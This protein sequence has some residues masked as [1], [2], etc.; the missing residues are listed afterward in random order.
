MLFAGAISDSINAGL[1]QHS[2]PRFSS[3]YFLVFSTFFHFFA[4]TMGLY[5]SIDAVMEEEASA[6][7]VFS[8]FSSRY[9]AIPRGLFVPG[10]VY[11]RQLLQ[12]GSPTRIKSFL[13]MKA[14]SFARLE[15]WMSMNTSLSPSKNIGMDEKLAMFLWTIGHDESNRSVMERF[16]HSGETVSR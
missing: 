13:R 12:T 14:S 8:L 11:L 6:L 3:R 2:S 7:A 16:S 15:A 9:G 4:S 10:A 1:E 5:A